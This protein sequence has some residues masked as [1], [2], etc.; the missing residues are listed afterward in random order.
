MRILITGANGLLGQKLVQQLGMLPNHEVIAT[1]TGAARVTL[2]GNT[3]WRTLDVTDGDQVAQAISEERPEAVIHTA[4]MTNVDQCETDREGCQSLNVDAVAHLAQACAD[5]GS[6]LLHLSTDFIFDGAAGPYDEAATPNPVSIYGHAKLEAERVVMAQPGLRWGIGRTILVYGI[7]QDMSRSNIILWVKSSL[8][9]GK[10]IQV[11]DDQW[12]TPTLA[13]DLADGCLR[14]A[15]QQAE[16]IFNLGGP[17]LLTPYDM[18]LATAQYF[19]LNASL[20]ER[21]DGTRFTQPAKRPPRTGL[22]IDKAR[23]QLGYA[24]RTF[25]EGIAVLAGQMERQVA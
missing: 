22:V 17:D 14:M 11:V 23:T 8:E 2:P 15:L 24:P 9:A 21:V 1:G 12:R 4:A 16:G 10:R 7:A 19:G 6:Y 20:I 13:E 5:T 3:R 25:A 18:A